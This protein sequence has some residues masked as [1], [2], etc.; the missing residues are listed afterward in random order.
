MNDKELKVI[1]WIRSGMD[2]NAGIELLIS[3]NPKSCD[4]KS[5]FGKE[6]YQHDKVA[7]EICHSSGVADVLTWKP[8]IWRNG[9]TLRTTPTPPKYATPS[10]H[11]KNDKPKPFVVIPSNNSAVGEVVIIPEKDTIETKPLSEY[12][13]I[14]RRVI[15]EYA[16]LFQERSKTHLVMTEMPESNAA[17]VVAKRA[18]LF[19]LVK[20][21]TDRII[22]LHDAKKNYDENGSLPDENELFP[23]ENA[24]VVEPDI[25][26]LDEESLKKMKKNLQK[27]RSKDQ[28]LLDSQSKYK[29]GSKVPMPSGPK[30]MKIEARIKA[31]VKKIEEVET[32]LLKYVIKD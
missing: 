13:P 16:S 31:T 10:R 15:V 27:S 12:P 19:D 2:Y 23:D 11:Q 9:G 24:V 21:L 26:L 6:K 29:A 8:F 18:E 5:F 1:N 3:F 22:L 17:T 28:S 25:S 7:Y 20:S 4:P 32:A 30:R 14:I